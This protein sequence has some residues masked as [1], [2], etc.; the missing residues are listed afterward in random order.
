MEKNKK[1]I[2]TSAPWYTYYRK[3]DA[4]F[5]EDPDIEVKFNDSIMKLSIYVN[6]EEKADAISHLLPKAVTFG[7]IPMAIDVIPTNKECTKVDYLKRAFSGNPVFSKIFQVPVEMTQSNL[8]SY[9][10][11]RNNVVQ[12]WNDNLGDPHGNVST[13]YETIARDIFGEFQGIFY[14][15]DTPARQAVG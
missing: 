15:T 6:G 11:F 1:D 13:L 8:M 9:C 12:F 2:K 5:G 10:I 3:V 14:C 4:L 7:N